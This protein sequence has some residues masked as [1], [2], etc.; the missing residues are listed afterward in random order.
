MKKE[1]SGCIQQLFGFFVLAIVCGLAAALY[2]AS[3]AQDLSDI[4]MPDLGSSAKAPSPRR[5]L[6]KVFEES[7]KGNF[8]VTLSEKELNEW[9][10]SRLK[11]HQGGALAPWV[12]LNRVCVRLRE[13]IAEVIIERDV[14]GFP[15]TTSMFIQ[16]VQSK[17]KHSSTRE[18]Q[19]HGGEFIKNSSLPPRG[20]RFG[21]LTVPQG[22]LY[23]VMS[24]FR[25]LRDA[26]Q[27]EIE[28]GIQRM[29]VIQ[30]ENQRIVLDPRQ[31]AAASDPV[32]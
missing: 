6:K 15:L 31:Q 4:K 30:I 1:S 25:K 10:A 26:M 14:H 21:K 3:Q 2:V 11:L 19:F 16:V 27:D 23:L 5:D 12:K 28:L 29:T 24:D 18:I 7:V 32:F 20:G 22:F 8:V 9:L 17:T 13:E